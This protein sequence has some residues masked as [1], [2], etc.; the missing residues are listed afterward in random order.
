MTTLLSAPDAGRGGRADTRQHRSRSALVT[1]ARDILEHGCLSADTHF[2]DQLRLQPKP[3]WPPDPGLVFRPLTL[4][5]LLT[6]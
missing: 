6:R 3:V 2:Y 1:A 5:V 4:L